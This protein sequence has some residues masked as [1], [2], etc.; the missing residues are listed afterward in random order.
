MTPTQEL[1]K[2]DEAH[3]LLVTLT[4]QG[5]SSAVLTILASVLSRMGELDKTGN[6]PHYWQQ[7]I[8]NLNILAD[9]CQAKELNE[10][11][12]FEGPDDADWDMSEELLNDDYDSLY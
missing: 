8:L 10:D 6:D 7:V 1:R 9:T 3:S 12:A 4:E 2:L 5:Q 11:L